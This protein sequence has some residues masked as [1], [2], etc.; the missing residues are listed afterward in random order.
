[1][2]LRRQV[3]FRRSSHALHRSLGMLM[4]LCSACCAALQA[5]EEELNTGED[6]T[7]PP[8]R[9]DLR[10][11]YQ[12]KGGGVDQSNYILRRDVT[13]KLSE[14]WQLATRL[15]VPFISSN[16]TG[17]NNPN[18]GTLFGLGDVLVQAVLIDSPTERFAFAGG[19]RGVFPTETKE[20]LGAGKYQLL[21]VGG[22]RWKLPELS[23]GSFFEFITLYDCDLGGKSNRK[24]IS[25]L[26]MSPT[27]NIALPNRWFVELFP[28]QDIV[29]NCL[30]GHKWFVP[31]D[32]MIGRNLTKRVVASLELSVPLIKEF[33]LY[34]FKLQARLSFNF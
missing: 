1:M 19:L 11:E 18:G 13:W 25:E 3:W 24:H 21:P 28:S 9:Y 10:Y 7:R 27:L 34:D 29:L 2:R 17:S 4:V 33:T 6:F 12:N 26:Q 8:T 20:E 23:H 30:D 32:I 14:Q 16:E 15:D 5:E 22:V 31:A